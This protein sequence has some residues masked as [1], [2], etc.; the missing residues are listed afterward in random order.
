[1]A[2]VRVDRAMRQALFHQ[3]LPRKP[4]NVAAVFFHDHQ[5]EAQWATSLS[6]IK[7]QP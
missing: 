6:L 1:M 4:Y 2:P 7:S 5:W 3:I